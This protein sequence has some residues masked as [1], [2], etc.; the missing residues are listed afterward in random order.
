ME[1]TVQCCAELDAEIARLGLELAAS[2]GTWNLPDA[3]SDAGPLDPTD[4]GWNK[5]KACGTAATE[6]PLNFS[7][8]PCDEGSGVGG[9]QDKPEV[10]AKTPRQRRRR[11]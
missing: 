9:E 3:A 4:P 8:P 2:G 7:A 6:L 11:K 1:R 5:T 10:A